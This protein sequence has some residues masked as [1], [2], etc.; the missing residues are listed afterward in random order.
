M[1]RE[2]SERFHFNEEELQF[3]LADVIGEDLWGHINLDLVRE[4]EKSPNI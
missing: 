1:L 2:K 4:K 3:L